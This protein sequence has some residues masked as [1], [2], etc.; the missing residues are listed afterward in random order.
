MNQF[1]A[2]YGSKDKIFEVWQTTQLQRVSDDQ[3]V[4]IL[5]GCD[6]ANFL[7]AIALPQL[8]DF[9]SLEYAWWLQQKLSE[10]LA[11][12]IT[13][14]AVGIGDHNSGLKFC[15]FTGFPESSLFIDPDAKFHRSLGL[16][17]GLAVKLPILSVS[18][19]W[20]LD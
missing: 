5:D 6:S 15:Q 16:Y 14:R 8:G 1:P 13:I 7:L 19:N 20:S 11:A 3:I 9:D 12:K 4:S 2:M 10:E 17:E 18:Q